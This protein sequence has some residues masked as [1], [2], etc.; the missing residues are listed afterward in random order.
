MFIIKKR[1][2]FMSNG[3]NFVCNLLGEREEDGVIG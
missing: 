2:M 1:R 3:F